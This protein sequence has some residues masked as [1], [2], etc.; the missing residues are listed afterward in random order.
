MMRPFSF[1]VVP[2]SPDDGSGV[3]IAVAGQ[4]MIDVQRLLTDIGCMLLRISM[5]LQNEIPKKLIKKFDLTIG[6]D[7]GNGLSSNPRVGNDEALE[8]AM[9]IL[10]STLDFLGTG[11]TGTWMTDTFEDDEARAVIARDLIDLADHLDGYVLEYGPD[12]EIRGF[13]GLNREKM[14][15]HTDQ[16]DWIGAAVGKIERD[17]VKK[18][19]WNIFN[20]G[21]LVP[22]SFDRNIA[23]SDIPTFSAAGPVIVVGKVQRNK[24]GHITS[25]DKISGC[26][27]I[28][29]MKFHRIITAEG[30]RN[31]LNP[32]IATTG[33]DSTSDMWSMWNDDVGISVSKPSWDECIVAFHEY[34]LFLF[35]NYVDTDKEFEGE[36]LEIREYLKS[37][38]PAAD[39]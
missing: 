3:P 36:E 27:T 14:L 9:N 16:K 32:L 23:S 19:H 25:V 22:L 30:D 21:Y 12:E 10:C 15:A 20:D 5:R 31:L 7:S 6:G 34:A 1:R 24:G 17:P 4:I 26:Y 37:L 11:A 38:L 2:S 28:P 18:N 8:G 33:Y 29:H 35:E 13:E 39:L